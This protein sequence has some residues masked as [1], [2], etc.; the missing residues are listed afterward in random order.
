MR[1]AED[2]YPNSHDPCEPACLQS[3]LIGSRRA[4]PIV[5]AAPGPPKRSII[6]C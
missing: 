6:S 1:K 4:E 3:Y 5:D 2:L